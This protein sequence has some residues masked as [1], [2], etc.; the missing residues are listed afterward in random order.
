M[1][2]IHQVMPVCQVIQLLSFAG[3]DRNTFKIPDHKGWIVKMWH[4][5]SDAS[6]EYSGP[7]F[8]V[9]YGI[10]Q[11]ALIRNYSKQMKDRKTRIRLERQ[12]YPNVPLAD[13]IEEKLYHNSALQ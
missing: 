1:A 6:I 8:E 5:G 12:E 4:F 3:Q 10:G 7:R 13:A 9:S 2:L 11:E